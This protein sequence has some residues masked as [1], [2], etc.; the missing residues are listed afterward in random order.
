M[1]TDHGYAVGD[2]YT[3]EVR[4][5][6]KQ[7]GIDLGYLFGNNKACQRCAFIE[8]MRAELFNACRKHDLWNQ[9]ALE[10]CKLIDDLQALRQRN[11]LHIFTREE[12]GISDFR[13]SLGDHNGRKIFAQTKSM[14]TNLG[15]TSVR[16]DN[17]AFTTV[18]KSLGFRFDDTILTTVII[19]IALF[20]GQDVKACTITENLVFNACSALRNSKRFKALTT[21]ERT[22]AYALHLVSNCNTLERGTEVE[23]MFSYRNHIFRYDYLLQIVTFRKRKRTYTIDTAINNKFDTLAECAVFCKYIT[24]RRRRL[25]I[26]PFGIVFA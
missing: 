23:C 5:T 18:E 15:Y 12:C 2:T 4:T 9:T 21:K 14:C 26:I 3:P 22:R 11:A 25:F 10:E 16:R 13:N 8:C 17:A 6:I 1:F 24:R 20:H 19:G 7:P